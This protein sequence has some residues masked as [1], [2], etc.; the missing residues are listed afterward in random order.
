[1]CRAISYWVAI[2]KRSTVISIA[3]YLRLVREI[4]LLHCLLRW[5]FQL[6][7]NSK[8]ALR[9]TCEGVEGS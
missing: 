3:Y 4:E 5:V 8:G 9:Q 6:H 2:D 1:M 7:L